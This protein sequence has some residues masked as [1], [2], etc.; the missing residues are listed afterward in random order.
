ME[1]THDQEFDIGKFLS[2]TIGRLVLKHPHTGKPTQ[3]W[4][5]IAGPDHPA[6]AAV[7]LETRRKNVES[8]AVFGEK[9]ELSPAEI[10]A[11]N[12]EYSV[13][14]ALGW[15]L[16]E[17]GKVVEFTQE[18]KERIFSAPEY[19]WLQRQYLARVNDM[20]LF[21]IACAPV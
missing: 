10:E 9:N 8:F 20:S 6:R 13:K 7:D 1:T 14:I 3:L 18:E 5:D 21:I 17:N 19:R 12:A 16:I 15:H 2:T 4:I 11:E